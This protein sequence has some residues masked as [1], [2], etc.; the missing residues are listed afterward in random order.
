VTSWDVSTQKG[1]REKESREKGSGLDA[2]KS[3]KVGKQPG[4]IASSNSPTTSG[5]N[6]DGGPAPSFG[7]SGLDLAQLQQPGNACTR[8]LQKQERTLRALLDKIS[9]HGPNGDPMQG[10]LDRHAGAMLSPPASQ[11][12]KLY[13]PEVSR[14]KEQIIKCCMVQRPGKRADGHTLG[15]AFGKACGRP[16]MAASLP[17]LT[18]RPRAIR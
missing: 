5:S 7:A 17:P 4:T 10:S 9:R 6:D 16:L 13:D 1:S 12:H 2:G 18:R 11:A 8:H 3:Q 15:A 14:L